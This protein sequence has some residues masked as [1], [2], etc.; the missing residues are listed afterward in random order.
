M[1]NPLDYFS[2]YKQEMKK[3][4]HQ[5]FDEEQD[6]QFFSYLDRLVF[7]EKYKLQDRIDGLGIL[8]EFVTDH[9]SLTYVKRRNEQLK[10][11]QEARERR[12]ARGEPGTP[13]EA[14]NSMM[15]AMIDQLNAK[16]VKRVLPQKTFVPQMLEDDDKQGSAKNYIIKQR[17]GNMRNFRPPWND[18]NPVKYGGPYGM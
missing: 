4:A 1:G 2:I 6:H 5:K 11:W 17:F 8:R 3:L 13:A 14:D 10:R 16:Q 12:I 9:A 7:A 18:P 15:R